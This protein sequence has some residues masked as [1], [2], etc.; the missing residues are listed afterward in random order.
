M[1]FLRR[2]GDAN[3]YRLGVGMYAMSA[4]SALGLGL[5]GFSGVENHTLLQV[6]GLVGVLLGMG[7][8]G[9]LVNTTQNNLIASNIGVLKSSTKKGTKQ[10]WTTKRQEGENPTVSF[11]S[12]RVREVFTTKNVQMRDS[13]RYQLASAMKNIATL[14][15][16]GFPFLF[17]LANQAIGSSV[18]ADFSLS[19]WLLGGISLYSLFRILRMP[20]KDSF[21][22]NAAVLHKMAVEKEAKIIK[23]IEKDL[24][25]NSIEKIDFDEIVRQLNSILGPYARAMAYATK[26]NTKEVA[27][28]LENDSLERIEENLLARGISQEKS[29]EVIQQIKDS[30]AAAVKREASLIDIRKKPLVFPALLSM[31]LLTVHELGTSSEFAYAVKDSITMLGVNPKEATTLGSFLAALVLY[32]PSFLFRLAGNWLALRISEGSMYTLSS[33]ASVMGT[34]LMIASHGNLPMLFAGAILAT[35]G[36][37]NFFSQMYEYTIQLQPKKRAELAVL[38][39]YTMPIAAGITALIHTIN[40]WGT[41]HGIYGLGLMI[42]QAA[43]I[44]SFFASPGMFA[45]SSIMQSFKHYAKQ[46]KNVFSKT[47]TPNNNV[48]LTPAQA[49]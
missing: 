34:G 31:T 6:G 2:I 25:E 28:Q 14:L 17:N 35:F 43:L 20:L 37:G 16:I 4:L 27:K 45:G 24:N 3:M 18:R 21:P 13:V 46:I 9:T 48:P 1:P 38:I 19:F 22:R 26:E 12:K 11:L 44:G 15:F 33:G 49:N 10:K 32:G 36:M 40:T 29:T 30:F 42:C 8:A 47:K 7:F 5:N 41:E 23:N 39:G